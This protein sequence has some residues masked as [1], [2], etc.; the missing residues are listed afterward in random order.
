MAVGCQVP[1]SSA[2]NIL[3]NDPTTKLSINQ[4]IPARP[5]FCCT[6]IAGASACSIRWR[7]RK[8]FFTVYISGL[9]IF[10]YLFI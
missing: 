7:K 5:V 3:L 2:I 9:N 1:A 10:I 6:E 4:K 8:D